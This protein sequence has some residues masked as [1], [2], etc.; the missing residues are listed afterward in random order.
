[1]YAGRA[2]HGLGRRQVAAAG[3]LGQ[4]EVGDLGLCRASSKRTLA[5]LQV[6]VDD[7]QVVGRLD[8][9]GERRHQ[10]GRGLRVEPAGPLEPVGEAAAGEVLHR[11][12][13]PAVGVAVLVDLD[14]VRVL[15]GGDGLGLGQ[16]ADQLLRPGPAARPGPSSGRPVRFSFGWR[17]FQTTPIPPSPR[18][19]SSS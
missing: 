12:E 15:D 17:A 9:V 16:E 13:R 10:L 4:A 14:D 5:G 18:G 8:G 19:S 3:P 11:Q 2:H 1:M 7:P 6:A